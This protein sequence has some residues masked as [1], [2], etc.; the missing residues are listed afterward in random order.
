MTR[1]RIYGCK[2]MM[3][4]GICIAL[5]ALMLSG[6]PTLHTNAN[7]IQ[8]GIDVSKWQGR[9]DWNAVARSGVSFAFIKA[10]SL[11]SGIDD[12]FIANMQGAKAAG[13]KT[14]VYI[15]SYATNVHEA[16][17]EAQFV[18]NLV[19]NLEVSYPIVWDVEDKVQQSLS[20]S[21][22]ALMANT[23]CALIEAEG[24]HPM[25]YANK[26]WF[27]NK[28]GN[29]HYDK[30]VAQWGSKL[31]IPDASV[32]QYSS[33]GRIN[34]IK[35]DVDLNFSLKD[36]SSTIVDTGFVAR[37]GA[38]YY[39]E[40][41]KMKKGW[42]DLNGARYL[43]D[44]TG[45]LYTGWLPTENGTFYFKPDG[46]MALGLT[47]IDNKLYYFDSNGLMLVGLHELAGL[48]FFF[49]ADGVM[50][51]GFLDFADGRRYFAA[52]GHMETGMVTIGNHIYYF[53][54]NGVM[55]TGTINIGGV[56]CTFDAEGRFI[57]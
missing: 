45:K 43:F 27:N 35:G 37:K 5:A 30:W 51:T 17:M 18:L 40:N 39:Y 20:A 25:V 32:W 38:I 7:T 14:G 49:G 33:T 22:L 23:F 26:Y 34:G 56:L 55:Q 44:G 19:Q 15:Y 29:I 3:K 12:Y 9:I 24:Y 11:K 47:L 1:G 50:Y 2:K 31:D 52:D 46:T 4:K 28:I 16:A 41:Y 57:G 21:T 13:I 48:K 10:G 36:F 8:T 54:A 42:L 6:V 53:D